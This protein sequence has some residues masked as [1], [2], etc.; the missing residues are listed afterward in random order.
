MDDG[1]HGAQSAPPSLSN[2]GGSPTFPFRIDIDLPSSYPSSAIPSLSQLHPPNPS[3]ASLYPSGS[4]GN[5]MSSPSSSFLSH[6][7]FD[8][9]RSGGAPTLR[10]VTFPSG[11]G[12][13]GASLNNAHS[14]SP[15]GQQQPPSIFARSGSGSGGGPGG[16]GGGGGGG[17]GN[18]FAELLGSAGGEHGGGGHGGGGGGGSQ[19]P[20]FDWPVHSSA[21]ASQQGTQG[22][23]ENAAASQG[24]PQHAASWFDF[25]SAPGTNDLSLPPPVP[26]LNSARFGV[27]GAGGGASPGMGRKRLRDDGAMSDGERDER[28]RERR[29]VGVNGHGNGNGSGVE[30]E[31]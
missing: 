14:Y 27:P 19:F 21:Q 23:H 12:G 9:A 5:L 13:G 28:E 30:R 24:A 31:S 22:G 18:I 26:P 17:P 16:S 3:L 4:I 1:S 6:S 15:H 7:P 8:L 25:L 2:V 20:G 11:G 10:S 29:S